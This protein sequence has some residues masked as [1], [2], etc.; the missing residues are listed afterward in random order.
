MSDS[1]QQGDLLQPDT[2]YQPAFNSGELAPALHYRSDVAREHAGVA[3]MRNFYVQ[4]QGNI[5][6]RP[7]TEYVG[8]CYK[9]VGPWRLV[10]FQFNTA[11]Q[12]VIEGGDHYF[13]II[14]QGAYLTNPDGSRYIVPTPYAA[15]ELAALRYVQSADVLTIVHT[16]HPPMDLARFGALDWRLTAVPEGTQLTGPT[17]LTI[18]T[19]NGGGFA[20]APAIVSFLYAVTA[21]STATKDESQLGPDASCTNYSTS[22]Y[23]QYGVYNTLVWDPVAGADFYKVYEMHQG[24]WS[25][26]GSTTATSFDD[27]GYA[28][29]TALS[30]P[31]GVNPF[32]DGNYPGVVGYFQER[33]IFGGSA[34]DPETVFTSKSGN[35]TNFDVSDPLRDDDAITFTLAARQINQ[36][37]HFVPLTDLII[38]T[39]GGGWR[40]DGSKGPVTPSNFD[41]APQTFTGSAEVE[42]IAIGNYI[43][44]VEAKGSSIREIVYNLYANSYVSEDRSVFSNHLFL[45]HQIVSWAYADSPHK[46]LW[47]VRDDGVLLSLTYLKEQ[48]VYAWA[49][50]DMAAGFLFQSVTVVSEPVLGG[51]EDVPYFLILDGTGAAEV[52]RMKSQI[53][54][55]GNNDPAQAWYLDR[56]LRYAGA[57]TT[58]ISGLLHLPN[59]TVSY[60]A[61]GVPGVGT[62]SAGGALTLPAPASVVLVG[63]AFTSMLTTLPFDSPREALIGK[64][65]RIFQVRIPVVLTAGVTL[66]VQ[67]GDVP[68]PFIGLAGDDPN[69]PSDL[70]NPATLV[71][72]VQEIAAPEGW[73]RYGQ[74]TLTAAGP[75]PAFISGVAVSLVLE[76]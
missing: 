23:Q 16:A 7:G 70:I 13:S 17:G 59:V 34:A 60:L 45:G 35:Y 38:M 20:T 58:T 74:V 55:A 52:V 12:Y 56:A 6:R 62:V 3:A 47:V 40:V 42:P 41:V 73:D 75:Q 24:V 43:L 76:G 27:Q 68:L 72:G 67:A 51:I 14:Y 53:L 4:V 11:Q 48:D 63:Q 39:G 9:N 21:C 69:D 2:F 61:D 50:H 26:I 32:A 10:A 46:V 29:D 31:T 49:R 28:P 1:Q 30:P 36:I 57:P 44:F 19:H 18:T 64:R 22:Y 5:A 33:R 54:G 66:T 37:R 25:F 8:G 15:G 71:T 65:R